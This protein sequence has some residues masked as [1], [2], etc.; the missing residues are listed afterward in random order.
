MN[1]KPKA[2]DSFKT[3]LNLFLYHYVLAKGKAQFDLESFNAFQISP[4]LIREYT[5]IYWHLD[6]DDKINGLT[7][8]AIYS[9]IERIRQENAA[10]IKEWESHYVHTT[11]PNLF[12]L[13]QFQRLSAVKECYYCGISTE[14]IGQLADNGQLNK[15]KDRGWNLEIDRLNSNLEYTPENCVMCCYWCN[16]AKTDEFTPEEFK[17]IAKGI[18]KV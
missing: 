1:Y 4:D 7:V 16:N 14:T 18:R 2:Q 12:P 17:E 15:K 9:E 5:T 3:K 6:Y 10:T 11:F 8:R 13:E